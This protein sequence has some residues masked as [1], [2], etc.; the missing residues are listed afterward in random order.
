VLK[1]NVPTDPFEHIEAAVAVTSWEQIEAFRER[2]KAGEKLTPEQY[3]A[4][5]AYFR[6]SNTAAAGSAPKSKGKSSA[7]TDAALAALADLI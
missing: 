1:P 7:A 4:I 2:A 3:R 5:L 6:Q